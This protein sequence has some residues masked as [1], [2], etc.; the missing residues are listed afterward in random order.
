M[1]QEL[2]TYIH[3]F[4]NNTFVTKAAYFL[5]YPLGYILPVFLVIFFTF[6]NK[7]PLYAFSLLFLSSFFSWLTAFLLKLLF[8]IPRPI[9]GI[10]YF[11]TGGYSFPSEHA[12]LYAALA[13]S[14]GALRPSWSVP[15]AIIALLV[16]LSRIVLGVHTPIDIL[17]G[18]I[19][20]T[21]VSYIIVRQFKKI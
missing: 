10:L 17:G 8:H 5:S 21:L 9:D 11:D 13:F 7:R 12:A 2:Y 20:G 18:F 6:K 19:V 3:N 1:N 15:M 4:S 16:G 14:I